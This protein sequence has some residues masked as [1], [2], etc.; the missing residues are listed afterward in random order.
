MAYISLANDPKFPVFLNK[1]SPS[2]EKSQYANTGDDQTATDR[3]FQ[4]QRFAQ[5]QNRKDDD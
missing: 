4:R 5:K 1:F 2:S 3:R